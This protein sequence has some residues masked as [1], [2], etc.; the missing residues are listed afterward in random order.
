MSVAY[1]ANEHKTLMYNKT[2]ELF[3][4]NENYMLLSIKRVKSTQ[5]KNV[6]SE[7]GPKVKFLIAKNKIMKK[8]LN[9]LDSKKYS[10]LI[11]MLHGDVIVAFFG[12][13]NP[14]CVLEASNNNMRQARAVPGDIA[15]KDVVI[16][17]GPTGLGPEKINIFQAAKIMTKINKGKIDLANDHKLLSSG[18]V[19]SISNARLLALL[20]ILPFEFGLDII[21]IFENGESYEKDILRIGE[22]DISNSLKEASSL[23]AALSIGS[24]IVTEASVPFEIRNA[25]ADLV[26]VSLATGFKIQEFSN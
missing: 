26:K 25:F 23:L 14:S 8:A 17:A 18:S 21:K 10:K 3:S 7:I 1:V 22:E 12:D 13:S 19:V 9:D 20:N 6:K 5:L 2:K 11:E 16:Q 4:A 15:L 24:G